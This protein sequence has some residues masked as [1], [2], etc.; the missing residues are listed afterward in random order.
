ME[1]YPLNA[2][3]IYT[4]V[5]KPDVERWIQRGWVQ[6]SA[7]PGPDGA[8]RLDRTD[9][10][11]V[12]FLKAVRDSGF[13]RDLAAD[14]INVHALCRAQESTAADQGPVAIAFSR[15]LRD[16]APPE[17]GAWVISAALD[18]NTGWD[19]LNLIAERLRTGADDIY[20]INFSRLR[21][22][23]DRRIAQALG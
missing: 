16:G 4:D 21:A 19:S 22:R 6:P 1:A 9:L 15:T 18:R 7:P 3:A 17:E 11:R 12:A 10:Y 13:S 2:V 5:G 14:R 8:P 20:V 23:V